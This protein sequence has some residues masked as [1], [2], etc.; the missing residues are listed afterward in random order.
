MNPMKS[1]VACG[2]KHEKE[3]NELKSLLSFQS[4]IQFYN[5]MFS[6]KIYC[7]ASKIELSAILEQQLVATGH[8]LI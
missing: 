2:L 4:L 7:D 3:F 6:T 8:I 5:L 1:N